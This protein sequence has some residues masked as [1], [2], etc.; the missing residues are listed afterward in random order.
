MEEL[1]EREVVRRT[2]VSKGSANKILRR[3]SEIEML[4]REKRGE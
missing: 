1:H 2:R 3:L 4:K